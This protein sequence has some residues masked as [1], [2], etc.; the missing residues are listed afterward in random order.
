MKFIRYRISKQVLQ[1]IVISNCLFGLIPNIN[2]R[3]FDKKVSI[4]FVTK[5][6]TAVLKPYIVSSYTLKFPMYAFFSNIEKRSILS[7]I[8]KFLFFKNIVFVKI[9]NQFFFDTSLISCFL[10][11]HNCFALFFSSLEYGFNLKYNFVTYYV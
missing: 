11:T 9:E 6:S 3:S 1:Q 10:S 2:V 4:K 7:H 5:K 8:N